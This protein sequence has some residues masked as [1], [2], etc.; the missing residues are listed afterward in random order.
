MIKF[1]AQMDQVDQALCEK[2]SNEEEKQ[3]N[4]VNHYQSSLTWLKMF[5]KKLGVMAKEQIKE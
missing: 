3:D 1:K 5:H 4:M 2:L